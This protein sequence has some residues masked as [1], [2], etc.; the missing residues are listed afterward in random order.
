[1]TSRFSPAGAIWNNRDCLGRIIDEL[2]NVRDVLEQAMGGPQ[3]FL[4]Q[5]WLQL[6][7]VVY[8]FKPDLIIE[9][10]R[11][12][13]NSTCA[14]AVAAKMLRPNPCSILSLCLSNVFNS[15]CRPHLSAN[16]S[17]PSLLEAITPLE[18]DILKYDFEP[19]ITSAKRIFIFWDV[20]GYDVAQVILTRLIRS[21]AERPHLAIV[22]DMADLSFF[23][24]EFRGYDAASLWAPYGTAAP[25]YILG[26]VGSQYEEGIALVDFLGRN[27]VCFY[28]A[29]SS[30][31]PDLTE[32]QAAE[33]NLLFGAD[34]SRYA[35]WYYFS[36]EEAGGRTISFPPTPMVPETPASIQEISPSPQQAAPQPSS[37]EQDATGLYDLRCFETAGGTVRYVDDKLEVTTTAAQWAY[38][39]VIPINRVRAPKGSVVRLTLSLEIDAG[40][41]QVGILNEAESSFITTATV[42]AGPRK[43]VELVI[44]R[45]D[46][47]GRLVLRNASSNG[48]SHGWCRLLGTTSEPPLP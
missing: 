38:T 13:G 37:H 36:L 8:D 3:D 28:S 40:T 1:M 16:L 39:A 5:Q 41:L 45:F 48:P 9:L 22:H 35:F 11:G 25:K 47:V 6:T 12:Y 17:D 14:M 15:I 33:L 7:S 29:E 24:A 10:G 44:P 27:Q 31:F 26:D 32:E 20:H 34:F 19:A 42:E 21:I 23:P 4:R 43:M 30:Y 2:R 46:R 18:A